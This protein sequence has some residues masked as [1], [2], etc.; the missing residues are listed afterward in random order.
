[1]VLLVFFGRKGTWWIELGV[2]MLGVSFG[3]IR[4]W[5]VNIGIFCVHGDG[6]LRLRVGRLLRDN[7]SSVRFIRCMN[8]IT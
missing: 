7:E 2:I 4:L 6:R 8:Y 1:M 3:R 5:F